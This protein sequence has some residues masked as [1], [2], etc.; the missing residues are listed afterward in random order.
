MYDQ[1]LLSNSRRGN[2][3]ISVKERKWQTNTFCVRKTPALDILMHIYAL[4]SQRWTAGQE[5]LHF[6]PYS[7]RPEASAPLDVLSVNFGDLRPHMRAIH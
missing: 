2:P 4:Y 6:W 1:Q 5:H 3:C 7:R